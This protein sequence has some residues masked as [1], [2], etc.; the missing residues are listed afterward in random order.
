M[1]KLKLQIDEEVKKLKAL[2]LELGGDDGGSKVR[3][4]I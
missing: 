3:L 4:K 2:K 1:I